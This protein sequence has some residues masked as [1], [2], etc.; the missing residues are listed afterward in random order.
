MDDWKNRLGNI[1]FGESGEH[2]KY[3]RCRQD[4]SDPKTP[5]DKIRDY[6]WI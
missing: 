2:L 1:I 5:Y 6:K 4:A 3:E